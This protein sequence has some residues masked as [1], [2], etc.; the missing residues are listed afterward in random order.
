VARQHS[1]QALQDTRIR[2]RARFEGP[3]Y[4][5]RVN[6]Y[7]ASKPQSTS[8][9]T[10]VQLR[11]A[12]QCTTIAN[13]SRDLMV[14]MLSAVLCYLGLHTIQSPIMTLLSLRNAVQCG[15]SWQG[16]GQSGSAVLPATIATSKEEPSALHDAA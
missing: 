14:A 6:K 2:S 16:C 9:T 12:V 15:H 5:A 11:N 10:I 3:Q 4:L 7:T 8:N 13:A 1:C